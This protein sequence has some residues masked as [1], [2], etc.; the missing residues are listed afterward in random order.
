MPGSKR[1]VTT[2]LWRLIATGLLSVSTVALSVCGGASPRPAQP[3]DSV[4]V[5]VN[6]PAASDG[7]FKDLMP[8]VAGFVL[9]TIVGGLLG[10]HLQ[11]RSWRFQRQET[12]R[13][14]HQA[15]ATKI[16][17]E[18]SRLLDQRQ[19][20]MSLVRWTL[21]RD[22]PDTK[23]LDAHWKLYRR[24]VF[25]W[26]D[27]VN[28]NRALILRYFGKDASIQFERVIGD[29]F[30]RYGELLEKWYRAKGKPD[31][32]ESAA[33]ESMAKDLSDAIWSFDNALVG[34]IR[35]GRVGAFH[36]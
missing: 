33:A 9:T 5:S 2:V 24:A 25:R 28:R 23:Q 11:N 19:Y 17:D 36:T 10:Y 20:R 26:N 31:P 22:P 13:E 18:V 1:T 7:P 32:T 4:A 3:E 15:E 34:Q 35:D 27:T 21:Q 6:A 29:G 12:L 14:L 30:V 8:I 16:F